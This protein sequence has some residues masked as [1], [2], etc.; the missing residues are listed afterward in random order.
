MRK[1]VTNNYVRVL[2]VYRAYGQ[3]RHNPVVQN[4]IVSLIK[5]SVDIV[6]YQITSGGIQGYLKAIFGI[7]RTV[8]MTQPDLIHAHYSYS[9]FVSALLSWKL[10]FICSL[11]G[12]DVNKASKTSHSVLKW[13]IRYIWSE[14]IVKSK[15]MYLPGARVIPNGIDLKIFAPMNQRKA[16]EKCK[17]N[18]TLKHVLFVATDPEAPVKNISLVYEVFDLLDAGY[19]LHV[20]SNASMNE[21]NIYYN[22]ADVLLLTSFAEGSPNVVK[23][24][25]A[26][27]CPVLST[28]VGDVK[29]LFDQSKNNKIISFNSHSI[30]NEIIAITQSENRSDGRQYLE[31]VKEEYI[32]GKIINIYKNIRPV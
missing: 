13:F 4:Q 9:G 23:E 7:Y 24:A 11:M 26:C 21:L 28:D 3:N 10:P 18:K 17:W 1:Y 8:R 27:N 31:A 32:S 12:S 16:Q 2:F 25:M 22:A 20:I 29:K 5:Q 6:E 14:T 19:E 30:K 15:N